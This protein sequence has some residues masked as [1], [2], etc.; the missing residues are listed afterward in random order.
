M[1][2]EDKA[3]DRALGFAS[4]DLLPLTK[5]FPNISGFYNIIDFNGLCQGQLKVRCYIALY[6]IFIE[7][8]WLDVS[9]RIQFRVAAT[10]N[11]CLHNMAFRYLSD[12]CK[13]I[14]SLSRRQSLRSDTTNDLVIPRVR[15]ATYGCRAFSVAGPVCWN[16]L[17]DYLKSPDLSFDR[18][19]RQLKT[20]LFC[21]Y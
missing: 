1:L 19:K 13:P 21:T 8:H 5:G 6:L 20:F 4:V 3:A 2:I 9:E 11:R 18:F 15:R 10:V 12:M 7:L 16:G 14:A 17:P